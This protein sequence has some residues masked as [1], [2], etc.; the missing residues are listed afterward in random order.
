MRVRSLIIGAI[1]GVAFAAGAWMA[2]KTFSTSPAARPSVATLLP[3]A[4]KLPSFALLDQNG[5]AIDRSVFEGRWDLV[6]FGFTNC[7]DVCPLTLQTLSAARQELTESGFS[8]LP[9]NVLVSVDPER[10]TPEKLS[11]YLSYFGSDNLGITGSIDE[12][13]KLTGTL[14]IFFDKR[15]DE[16]GGY[17]VDHSA[18][19]LLI[20]P[21]ARFRALFSSPHKASNFVSDLPVLMGQ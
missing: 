15:M 19:V 2:L 14:G 4:I 18:V 8:P 13:R 9:R 5:D 11:E 1:L 12:L 6:F 16:S 17:T 7:P 3:V 21:D 20:D 10:D